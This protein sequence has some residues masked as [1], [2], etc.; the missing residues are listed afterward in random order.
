MRAQTKPFWNF[1]RNSQEPPLWR[2]HDLHAAE[3]PDRP[4]SVTSLFGILAEW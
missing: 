3:I 4:P 2:K 1:S